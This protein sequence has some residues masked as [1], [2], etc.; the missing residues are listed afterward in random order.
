MFTKSI[1]FRN[2]IV[3]FIEIQFYTLIINYLWYKIIIL[4]NVTLRL[5]TLSQRKPHKS[6]GQ[7][8]SKNYKLSQLLELMIVKINF[9][10]QEMK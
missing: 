4:G 3:Y 1:N 7:R 9:V 2:Y 8:I 10:M 6:Q 5:C